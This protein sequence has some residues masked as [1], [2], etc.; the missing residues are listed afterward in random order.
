MVHYFLAFGLLLVPALLWTL[1]TGLQHDGSRAHFNAGLFTAVLAL[2]VHTLLILFMVVTGRVLKEAMRT[3]P[4]GPEFLAELNRFFAQQSAYPLA[5]LASF[6]I[7]AAAVLGHAQRGFGLSAAWHVSIGAG[8]ILLNVWACLAEYRAL[9]S[10][11]ALL[12]RAALELDRLDRETAAAGAAPPEPGE[13]VRAARFGLILAL[14]A[15]FPYVYWALIHWRGDFSRV[16]LHP[17][18]E[19]SVFGLLVWWIARAEVDGA[20]AK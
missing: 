9:R 10:N 4:L 20:S 13:P 3:R 8:A 17:W 18:I 11:Q 16:S 6:A 19:A 1:V 15:W 12:D 7:V 5:I 14:S 2:A